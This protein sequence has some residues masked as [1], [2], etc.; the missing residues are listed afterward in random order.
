MWVLK[1]IPTSWQFINT[2]FSSFCMK[3]KLA[4]SLTPPRLTHKTYKIPE[5]RNMPNLHYKFIFRPDVAQTIQ[6]GKSCTRHSQ[7][8]ITE[9]IPSLQIIKSVSITITRL[10]TSG[11]AKVKISSDFISIRY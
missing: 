6:D 4:Y 8:H 10:G 5:N 11:D 1:I 3:K 9:I 2:M 7:I